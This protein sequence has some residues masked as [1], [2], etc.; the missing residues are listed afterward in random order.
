MTGDPAMTI[1]LAFMGSM[2][3]FGLW[4]VYLL[5][6]SRRRRRLPLSGPGDLVVEEPRAPGIGR[7][8]LAVV[9]ISFLVWSLIVSH[10]IHPRR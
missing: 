7:L 3:A 4:T 9:L 10:H 8:R 6:D 2:V 5:A 1:A